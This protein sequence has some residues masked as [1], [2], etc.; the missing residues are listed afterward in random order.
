MATTVGIYHAHGCQQCSRRYTDRCDTPML[1]G[2][3]VECRIDRPRAVWDRAYDPRPCCRTSASLVRDSAEVIRYSLG[4][5]G[6]WWKCKACARTHPYD[7]ATPPRK[8]STT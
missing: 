1:N 8:K 4:G 5:S 6:P 7:P 2:R 3:C